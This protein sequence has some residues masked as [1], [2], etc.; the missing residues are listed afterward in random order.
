[1][2][3]IC[4]NYLQETIGPIIKKII[5]QHRDCEIDPTKLLNESGEYILN[6]DKVPEENIENLKGINVKYIFFK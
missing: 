2:K 6:A 1:M 3:I 5:K 4:K